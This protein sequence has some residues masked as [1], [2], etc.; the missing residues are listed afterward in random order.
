MSADY[1]PEK[2]VPGLRDM[3]R[4]AAI[5]LAEAAG[6]GAAHMLVLGAGGGQELASFA[7]IYPKWRFTGVDPSAEMLALARQ[8]TAAF[9]ARMDLVQGY[10]DAAPMGPFDGA[11]CLLTLHFLSPEQRLATLIAIRARM[12]AGAKLVV[13][14]HS[15]DDAALWLGR[16]AQFAALN[17]VQGIQVDAMAEKLPALSPAEDA[18]LLYEAG[19]TGVQMFYAAL[20]FRGWVA[21]NP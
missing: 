7:E 14:H 5:L 3:Q 19:F 2:M 12:R 11:T 13:A 1:T 6:D 21:V 18:R 8:K 9:R 4:M 10:I 17:G 16:F 15:Y 20:S